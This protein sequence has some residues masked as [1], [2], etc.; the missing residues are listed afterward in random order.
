MVDAAHSKPLMLRESEHR[1][2]VPGLT[3][4]TPRSAGEV[5]ELIRQ[6]NLKRTTNFTEANATSSRSHAVL[7]VNLKMKPRTADISE[8]YS[9]STLSVID[10][11]GSERARVT[12]N[13]GA[14]LHEGANIN[15]SLLALGNCINALCDP[16]QRGHVPFRNSKLTRLLKHSLTGNCRTQLIVC[17]S[18]SSGH[19]DE[20]YNTL[21]YANRAKDIKTKVTRNVVCSVSP[22]F[23]SLMLTSCA[24]PRFL[25]TG[26]CPN[27]S[28]SSTSSDKS[29]TLVRRT[30]RQEKLRREPKTEEQETLPWPTSLHQSND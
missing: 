11:A 23:C 28:R 20:T 14:R 12:N 25:S 30:T 8:S 15:K 26:M 27:T 9:L 6:G 3:E 22:L 2:V 29:W 10:L 18:P 17:V 24:S 13:K 19:Y 4:H 7:S 21:Q 16:K 1:V 5:L